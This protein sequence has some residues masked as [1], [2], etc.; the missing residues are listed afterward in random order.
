MGEVEPVGAQQHGERHPLMVAGGRSGG[1]TRDPRRS[2]GEPRTGAGPRS[3]VAM[4]CPGLGR[5]PPDYGARYRHPPI[6]QRH[7]AMGPPPEGEPMSERNIVGSAARWSAEPRTRTCRP[8]ACR[9]SSTSR[10]ATLAARSPC[11]SP[12]STCPRPS[13][14]SRRAP[15]SSCSAAAPTLLPCRRGHPLRTL[16]AEGGRRPPHPR[17]QAARR[18]GVP[19]LQARRGGRG[20]VRRRPAEALSP[21]DR[22]PATG[23]RGAMS[24]RREARLR[25]RG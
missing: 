25:A 10:R 15:T 5:A 7:P 19:A 18:G 24:V 20:G 1:V 4:A 11:P 23:T 3:S 16:V 21:P 6:D 22:P 9:A 14:S 13:A 17:R 12:G 2:S 8:A